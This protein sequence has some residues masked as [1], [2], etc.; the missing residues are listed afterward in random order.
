[1][2]AGTSGPV[3]SVPMH[4][5]VWSL[6]AIIAGTFMLQGGNGLLGT[7]LSLRL[8][9]EGVPSFLIGIV[10]ASYSA[11]FLVTCL[12]GYRLIRGVGHIRAF[13]VC[14]ALMCCVTLAFALKV[15]P[16][17]WAALR[18]LT[19]AAAAG[20][21]M[22]GESWLNDRTPSSIRGRVFAIYSLSNMTAQSSCQ[23]LL[24]VADPAGLAFFMIT[25]GLFSASLIPVA[26][27]RASA[28]TLPSIEA[29]GLRRLFLVSPVAVVGCICAGLVNAS[30]GGLAPVFA[31]GV[32]LG[33][34]EVGLF[35]AALVLGGMLLQW[36]LGRLSDRYDRRWV[37][38]G[39]ALTAG[40]VALS[41]AALAGGPVLGLVLLAM[42]FGGS[43]YSVYPLCAS[44]ANDHASRE[45]AV[46]V[47]SGLLLSWAIGSIVGP[48]IATTS[49]GLFGPSGL[50][51]YTASI[52]LPLALYVVWRMT[53]R[54]PVPAEQRS[55]FVAQASA[56][57]P[58][59]QASAVTPS[60]QAPAAT[61]S[62][63][64]LDPRSGQS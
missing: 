45:H 43:A 15:D 51:F 36:P 34:A 3:A 37:V 61:P 25:A 14:G 28:P 22:I 4:S 41:L 17:V 24:F 38:L 2:D 30:V 27:T 10:V 12:F 1:M 49:M 52:S 42:A 26:L 64:A 6:A 55:A 56:V 59:A 53:R 62:A 54:A 5:A 18:L 40:T 39:V 33:S 20:M 19:G 29:F 50:F 57:T 63:T 21:F 11:G 60:A 58:S 32:G 9:L 8:A 44:H 47:S 35:T 23:L 7:F 16:F 13:A 48:L 31:L 46:G